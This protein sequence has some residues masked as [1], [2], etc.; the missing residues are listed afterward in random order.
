MPTELVFPPDYIEQAVNASVTRYTRR[1]DVYEADNTTLFKRGAGLRSG[2]ITIDMSR[3]ER[4]TADLVLFNHDGSLT[5]DRT[6]GFWYDKVLRIYMGVE[7]PSGHWEQ[8]LGCFMPD[9]IQ[10]KNSSKEVPVTARDFSKKLS[11]QIPIALGWDVNTPIENIIEDMAIGGGIPSGDLDLPITGLFIDED[12]TINSGGSRFQAMYDL[13]TAFGYDLFF[14]VTGTLVMQEFTD[15]YTSQPQYTFRVGVDANLGEIERNISDAL[16]FNHV[17]VEGETPGGVPVWGEAFNN[18]PSSPTRITKL[19]IRSAPTIKN[20]WV[21]TNE[22]AA[23]V[24]TRQ[25]AY[26]SLERYEADLST[27]IVP[28]LDV[29]ITVNFDDPEAVSGDPNRFLLDKYEIS[30]DLSPAK[31]HVGRVTNLSTGAPTYP[32]TGIYPS[33]DLFPGG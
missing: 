26:S 9:K 4:R 29:G 24:A 30:L 25:L 23:D 18:D 8:C 20:S 22:Q 16:V 12:K 17:I 14:D 6:D 32:D 2:S 19:G 33:G 1:V 27:L 11:F 3:P 5:V 28:W 31:A 10:G 7:S 21:V 15:P 13:A